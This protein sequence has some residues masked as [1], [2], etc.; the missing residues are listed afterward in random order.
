MFKTGGDWT[1]YVNRSL[2]TGDFQ[3][4]WKREDLT[5]FSKTLEKFRSAEVLAVTHPGSA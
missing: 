5:I 4:A 3:L 1:R 2:L